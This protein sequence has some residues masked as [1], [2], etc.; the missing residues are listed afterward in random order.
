VWPMQVRSGK[1]DMFAVMRE[2]RERIGSPVAG[3]E[4]PDLTS[5]NRLQENVG[6]RTE[7]GPCCVGNEAAVWREGG[8]ALIVRSCCQ[9]RYLPSPSLQEIEVPEARSGCRKNDLASVWR[10]RKADVGMAA[11]PG[12]TFEKRKDAEGNDA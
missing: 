6:R 4:L 10:D 11:R 12:L 7:C 5:G 3:G 2:H 8:E 1:Q 9:P